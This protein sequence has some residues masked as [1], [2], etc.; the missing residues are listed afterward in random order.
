MVPL[1]LQLIVVALAAF[2]F[3]VEI[4]HCGIIFMIL[5]HFDV[6]MYYVLLYCIHEMKQLRV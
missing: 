3:A 1:V 2:L 4:Y 6:V 5:P